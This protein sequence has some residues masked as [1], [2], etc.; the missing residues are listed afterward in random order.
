MTEKINPDRNL[1]SQ[2]SSHT[3]MPAFLSNNWM[4]SQTH[5]M[6]KNAFGRT[7]LYNL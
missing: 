6:D 2:N 1:L 7:K 3:H 4:H 5:E